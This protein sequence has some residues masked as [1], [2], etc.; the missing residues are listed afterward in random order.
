MTICDQKLLLGID[1]IEF[2]G[3]SLTEAF[4]AKVI[5][6]INEWNQLNGF[7]DNRKVIYRRIKL[8]FL[9]EFQNNKKLLTW[10]C[11]VHEIIPEILPPS[12]IKSPHEYSDGAHSCPLVHFSFAIIAYAQFTF[13]KRETRSRVHR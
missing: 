4:E 2:H 13:I 7:M 10:Q 12:S 3:I 8:Q 6:L 9:T 5:E 11:I 1:L